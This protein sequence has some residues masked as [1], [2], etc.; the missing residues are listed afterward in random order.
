MPRQPPL[1]IGKE[2]GREGLKLVLQS[3]PPHSYWLKKRLGCGAFITL[4]AFR[5]LKGRGWLPRKG[6]GKGRWSN[7]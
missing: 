4:K 2:G 6:Y 7:N 3:L 1:Y 5:L